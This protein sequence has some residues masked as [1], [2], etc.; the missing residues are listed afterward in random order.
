[1]FYNALALNYLIFDCLVQAKSIQ[2]L[3]PKISIYRRGNFVNDVERNINLSSIVFY[4]KI[5]GHNKI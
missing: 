1:M 4:L 5:L 2:T 3:Q